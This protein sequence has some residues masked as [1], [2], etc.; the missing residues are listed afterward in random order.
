MEDEVSSEVR[1]LKIQDFIGFES[2]PHTH[3]H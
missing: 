1:S 3:I 2:T